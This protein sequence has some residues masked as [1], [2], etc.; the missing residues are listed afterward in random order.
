MLGIFIATAIGVFI[1]GIYFIGQ[2]QRLFSSTIK[3]TFI[4]GDVS[5]LQ[6]GNNVRFSGINVGTVS[7]VTIVTDSTVRV[8]LIIDKGTQ[9][10]IKKDAEATVGSEGLMGD[11]IVNIAS[12]SA[13]AKEIENNDT[14]MCGKGSGMEQIMTQLAITSQN[15]ARITSDIAA[16]TDNIRQGKGTVGKLFM[17]TAMAGE[18]DQTIINAKNAAGGLSENME[19]AKHNILFRGYFKKKEAEKKKEQNEQEK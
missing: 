14:I 11:K 8:D 1:A 9:K 4:C 15:A 19:A 18:I 17:D 5:G 3:V 12:G 7:R 13:G 6:V 16:I 2:K 10:F